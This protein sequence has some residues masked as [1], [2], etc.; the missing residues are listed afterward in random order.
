MDPERSPVMRRHRRT[1]GRAYG[2]LEGR[3]LEWDGGGERA[4]VHVADLP[5]ALGG[6]A[7]H[8]VANALAAA[9]GARAM[10]AT[11]AQ[12]ADGL[13]DF[14]PSAELSPG[15]MNLFQVGDRVVI[16]DFAHNEAGTDA[17]LEVARGIADGA[18]VT[19]IIGTAG[20]RPDDT[21]RGIGRSAAEHA[22]RVAIKETPAYLR[23]RDRDGLVAI[24][25]DGIRAGGMDPREVPV[26]EGEERALEV[27]LAL[28]GGGDP[29][30][31][32]LF[33]HAERDPVFA[34]LE[35]LGATPVDAAA[36]STGLAATHRP[37]R[38]SAGD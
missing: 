6:L 21:L 29:E 5:V 32:V 4:I 31:I 9:A 14:R 20:D 37:A 33:C 15:R 22:D 3:L 30:V 28:G 1:G 27:E 23:G 38:Q 10:G 8:N 24:I 36:V 17:I 25:R 18:P 19:A 12:V 26:Y 13:R 34:L 35:R 11:L 2:L 7:R 16:V